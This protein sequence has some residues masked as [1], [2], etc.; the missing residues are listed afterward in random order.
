MASSVRLAPICQLAAGVRFQRQSMR[1]LGN[2]HAAA[3]LWFLARVAHS[4]ESVCE[5][6]RCVVFEL[7]Y[8]FLSNA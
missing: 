8:W 4:V 6:H 5:M 7:L 3:H 2:P 1:P